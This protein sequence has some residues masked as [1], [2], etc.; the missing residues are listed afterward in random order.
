MPV[1]ALVGWL[2]MQSWPSPQVPRLPGK[3]S[4]P[5]IQDSRSGER[6]PV[7]PEGGTAR[8]YACGI[9]PYDA[10]HLG[11]AFTYVAID[12]LQ[13]VWLDAGLQVRYAQNITD[14][15]D[16]LL[17]RANAT[18]ADWRELATS[19]IELFRSDMET[20]RV[21]PPVV[22]RGVVE[23]MDDVTGLIGRLVEAG[24]GYR[25]DDGSGD[26]YF[27][28]EASSDSLV[29]DPA[30]AKLQIFAERGGDPE[31]PG[32]RHRLDPLIWR[33]ERPGEPVWQPA[34]PLGPGRPGWHVECTAIALGALGECFDVQAGGMDL[35]FPHHPM[36][37]AQ[38]E[39]LTGKPFAAAYLHV[40]MVGLNGE[41]MSKSLGNLVF[42]HKLVER[43]VD[44]M[45]IRLLLLAHHYRSDWEYTETELAAA[46][47][48]LERW[49]AAAGNAGGPE[50][51]EV[52][53]GV[54]EALADDLDAPAALAMI[55]RWADSAQ[56]AAGVVEAVDALLGVRLR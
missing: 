7:G 15:D 45:A 51:G 33:G 32:K 36:C 30:E 3:G 23:S 39:V 4:L 48:R 2:I 24:A 14:V 31:R 44:P 1:P 52:L 42:A 22:Y 55:D 26:W 17:E 49:R 29:N 28:V 47:A 54:R 25:L 41:K 53:S 37:A 5:V 19:Q 56:P 35:A 11:H 43:G 50:D 40:G 38:A 8:I 12:L 16:P 9:T 18:G 20:L 46:V 21:L 27:N 10:T 34:A 13:R 6:M